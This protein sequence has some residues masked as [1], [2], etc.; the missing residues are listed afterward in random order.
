MRQRCDAS[1]Q[2]GVERRPTND[3]TISVRG[4]W[5]HPDKPRCCRQK[6]FFA[7]SA[8]STTLCHVP[9]TARIGR[10]TWT[11][12]SVDRGIPDATCGKR[13][14]GPA[15]DP[16]LLWEIS[17]VWLKTARRC[18]LTG[19][20]RRTLALRLTPS[21]DGNGRV[22]SIAPAPHF[23]VLAINEFARTSAL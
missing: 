19:R 20:W 3:I 8:P 17:K 18:S 14:N 5:R 23:R 15:R 7:G 6:P 9:R 2:S 13:R 4:T 11:T 16:K 10:W 22:I 1:R 21:Y 12:V